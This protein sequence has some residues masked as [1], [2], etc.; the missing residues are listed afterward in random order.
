MNI[1]RYY[2]RAVTGDGGMTRAVRAAAEAAAAFGVRTTIVYDPHGAEALPV[3]D[4]DTVRW[5]AVPHRG[6][7]RLRAPVGL[8]AQLRDADLLVL[9]SA[10][11][12]QNVLAADVAR[13]TGVPYLLEPRGAY[14]PHIV[15]RHR[16]AKAAWWRAAERRLVDDAVAVHVF[17][18]EEREHVRALGYGG[19]IIVAPNGVE[20]AGDLA[21]DGS[22]GYVLW[23]GR[24]DPFHK[25]LDLLL[26]AVRA[27]PASR[28]PQVRLHGPDWHGRKAEV[29]SMVSDMQLA[30]WVCV[31]EQLLGEAKRDAL[32]R[33]SCFVYPSRWEAFGNSVAE[34]ASVGLPVLTT[35]YPLGR[36]LAERDAAV[37]C[38]H[39]VAALAQGLDRVQQP[40]A[41]CMGA[42]ARRVVETTMQWEDTARR[43]V[44]QVTE[45]LG[46]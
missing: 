39:S 15:R 36:H 9:H 22:G 12:S 46:R 27:L 4:T 11:T 45:V 10:W 38:M 35:W 29:Q 16:P 34:A 26:G 3:A 8:A 33:A 31:G 23:L 17:F 7:D 41:P 37:A 25:G 2:P 5:R 13:H 43:W 6:H 21:A 14:D 18:D 20:P 32:T 40:D 24:F 42:N 28:R 19:P 44:E 1:V 30:P